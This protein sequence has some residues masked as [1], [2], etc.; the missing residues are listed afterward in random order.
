[1]TARILVVDDILPNVRLLEARLT[2]EYFEVITATNGPDA[3]KICGKG[4]C[5]IVLL[6]VMMPGMDGFEV[7]R[8][9]KLDP[10]TAHIPVVMVTALDQ[11]ADRVRGLEAGAD[12]FLTKPID[13]IALFARVRSLSRMRLSLDELRTRAKRTAKLGIIDPLAEAMAESGANG[14]VM[15]ID[16]RRSSV[17][18][19]AQALREIHDVELETDAKEA[20]AR[21]SNGNYDLL[22]VSLSLTG[23]D[24][25]RLCSQIRSFEATRQIPVL[26][27]AEPEDREKIL[28]CLEL[29][30]NDYLLRPIDRNELLARVRT[31]VRRKRYADRLRQNVETSIEM[32][33]VDPLTGL[34][35]RRY[36]DAALATLVDQAGRRAKP[37]SLMMLDIDRFKAVNDIYG[38]EAGDQIL[39]AFAGRV[40]QLIRSADIFCRLSGDEFV[41]AM[42]GAD[43]DIA[44]KIAERVRAGVAGDGFAVPAEKRALSVTVSIGLAESVND[45]SELMRRADKALYRSKQAGRNRIFV[46]AGPIRAQSFAGP[47]ASKAL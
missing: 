37:L 11:A 19:I 12:D 1:M 20:L 24:G 4:D 39:Q 29:G 32:A 47:L 35:N 2:A 18:R 15:V 38:H 8:R 43:V 26:A 14:R 30:A 42:P 46:D 34:N 13:E 36:L 27:V 41:V 40:K 31:Q 9:L 17:E 6:D 25:L 16:D 21:S 7:C 3:L 5:D 33:V 10:T 23:Y 45:A 44:A 22:I 28:H